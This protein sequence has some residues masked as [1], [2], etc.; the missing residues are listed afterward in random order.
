MLSRAPAPAKGADAT[1]AC[2]LRIDQPCERR[3]GLSQ[4][5]TISRASA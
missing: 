3:V 2:S 5:R 4:N 1:V